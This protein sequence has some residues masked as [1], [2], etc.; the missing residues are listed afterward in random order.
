MNTFFME[1]CQPFKY[2]ELAS[3]QLTWR[4]FLHKLRKAWCRETSV[5]GSYYCYLNNN[6]PS[7]NSVYVCIYVYFYLI[8]WDEVKIWKDIYISGW[9]C[10]LFKRGGDER[11]R[12]DKRIIWKSCSHEKQHI[13]YLNHVKYVSVWVCTAGFNQI[14]KMVVVV[15]E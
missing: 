10:W 7:F 4:N 8:Q 11:G 15:S 1:Y 13:W 6:S 3:Y 14:I 9:W 2:S 12:G 5:M